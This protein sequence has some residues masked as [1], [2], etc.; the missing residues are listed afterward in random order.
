[1][2]FRESNWNYIGFL[3]LLIVFLYTFFYAL[4]I[5]TYLCSLFCIIE[6]FA[7]V[8]LPGKPRLRELNL[9]LRFTVLILRF[10]SKIQDGWD[11][12]HRWR[13]K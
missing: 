13:N 2:P 5:A 11:E 4:S 10:F 3:L 9:K 12:Y 8:F 1:M 7:I 6:I